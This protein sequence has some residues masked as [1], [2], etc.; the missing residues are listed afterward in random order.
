MFYGVAKRVQERKTCF[1]KHGR[2]KGFWD[3]NLS[4]LGLGSAYY[5]CVNKA[6]FI[7]LGNKRNVLGCLTKCLTEIKLRKTS[8]NDLKHGGQTSKTCL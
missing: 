6:F 7:K 2:Q 1:T 5:A 3:R 4:K 8:S